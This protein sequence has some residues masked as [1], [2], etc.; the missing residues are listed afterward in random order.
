LELNGTHQFLVYADD[1]NISDENIYTIKKYIEALLEASKVGLEVHTEKTK[2]M[3]L[4]HHQNTRQ[5]HNLLIAN[6]D[7]EQI[8][9]QS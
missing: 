1:I 6:K 3:M 8:K 5:N 2:S 9:L 7:S 4:S